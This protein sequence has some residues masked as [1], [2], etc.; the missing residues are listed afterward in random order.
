M[1]IIN[2]LKKIYILKGVGEP[3]Y[4]LGG[5]IEKPINDHWE[6]MGITTALSATTYIKNSVER[7][8]KLF[9]TQFPSKPLPMQ[10]KDHP[11]LGDSPLCSP[12]DASKYRSHISSANWVITLGRFD[13]TYAVQSLSRFSMAPREGHMKRMINLFGYLKHRPNG[14]LICDPGSLIT[15]LTIQTLT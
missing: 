1:A 10:D 11:E 13:I 4:Y 15:Q 8:E 6:R 3:K 5:N 14:K 2:E 7:F 12:D 9:G